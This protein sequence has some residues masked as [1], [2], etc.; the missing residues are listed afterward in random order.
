MPYPCCCSSGRVTCLPCLHG[1]AAQY[2]VDL[3]GILQ[4]IEICAD[5]PSLNGSYV[6]DF[7]GSDDIDCTWRYTFPSPVCVFDL[8][9]LHFRRPG[10]AQTFIDVVLGGVGLAVVWRLTYATFGPIPDDCRFMS[11][12]DIPFYLFNYGTNPRQCVFESSAC[13]ITAM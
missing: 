5:C 7:L 9:E 11:E 1:A 3:S 12:L 10:S 6:L 4:D 2:Q 8:L 13:A